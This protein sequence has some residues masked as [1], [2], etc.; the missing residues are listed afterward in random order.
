MCR[1]AISFCKCPNMKVPVWKSLTNANAAPCNAPLTLRQKKV[2]QNSF[3][4]IECEQWSICCGAHHQFC[5]QAEEV[6]QKESKNGKGVK[7]ATETDQLAVARCLPE[8]FNHW[9]SSRWY[10]HADNLAGASVIFFRVCT[11][12]NLHIVMLPA[13]AGSDRLE[14][15]IG[16]ILKWHL[17][18]LWVTWGHCSL[19]RMQYRLLLLLAAKYLYGKQTYGDI[20]S[21]S[22]RAKIQ[23][24]I[25]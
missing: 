24:K 20:F 9:D 2:A 3:G 6:W 5:K 15:H 11:A 16:N 17:L 10:P 12:N 23:Q 25:W 21:T 13:I 1:R 19:I 18:G 14:R 8:G 22:L 4:R 7:E